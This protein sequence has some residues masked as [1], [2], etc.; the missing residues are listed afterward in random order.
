MK[1][2]SK[3]KRPVGRPQLMQ[4][5]K[6]LTIQ[7]EKR[8]MEIAALAGKGSMG[9]GVRVALEFYESNFK[10]IMGY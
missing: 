3:E 6:S 10:R 4:D 2:P 7:V 9:A 8:H 1:K 5:R